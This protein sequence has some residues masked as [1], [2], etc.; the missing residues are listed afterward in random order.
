M[1]ALR[2]TLKSKVCM[3]KLP[4]WVDC[5]FTLCVPFEHVGHEEKDHQRKLKLV[6]V[7]QYLVLTLHNHKLV[8]FS[9]QTV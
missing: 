4:Q 1:N 7:S 5:G 3:Q 8:F 9:M 6:A 2:K